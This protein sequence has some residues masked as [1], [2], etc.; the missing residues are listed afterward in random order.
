[1]NKITL[2]KA[3]AR[4]LHDLIVDA[5]PVSLTGSSVMANALIQPLPR[6]LQGKYFYSY[7]GAGT[8]QERIIGSL[9]PSKR[10]ILFTEVFGSIP[11]VNTQFFLTEYWAKSDYD[12]AVERFIGKARLEFL[13]EKVA[14]GAIVGSQYE[15]PVPSGFKYISTLRLVPS[16]TS[17]YGGDD[18][19]SRI[20][21]IP[22]RYW[23]IERNVGG[24]YL[25]TF[26]ARLIDL[27]EFDDY[28]IK[29]QGQVK[30]DITATDNA[31]IPEDL[32]EYLISGSCALLASQRIG[33]NQ[34]W[35]TKFAMFRDD[36]KP[37]EDYIHRYGYGRKVE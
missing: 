3:A 5:V 1:M 22:T 33:E 11:S 29:I 2:I 37:L 18:K 12:N 14:T 21:E 8:G 32:E 23:R 4:S 13:E 30:P 28:N 26:D 31:V 17:D 9:N 35:R 36:F 24:T 7:S 19:I 25:I 27:D 20:F 16:S 6:Q 15:Y 34:E 10:E